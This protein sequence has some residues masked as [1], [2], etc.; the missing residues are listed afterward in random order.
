MLD[1]LQQNHIKP[2][3]AGSLF[4]TLLLKQTQKLSG[5]KQ[6]KK[7]CFCATMGFS[8][9]PAYPSL[10]SSLMSFALVL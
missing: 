6:P 3:D 8:H 7:N 9:V 4:I 1:A 10:L 5:Q 2:C